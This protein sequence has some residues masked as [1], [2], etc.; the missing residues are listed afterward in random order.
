MDLLAGPDTIASIDETH[1]PTS[2]AGGE[3]SAATVDEEDPVLPAVATDRI[4][5]PT[6][7]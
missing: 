3:P 1:V 2:A 6:A 5:S 7:D 4:P